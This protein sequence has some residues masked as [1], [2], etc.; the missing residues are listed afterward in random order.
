MKYL[1]LTLSLFYYFSSSCYSQHIDSLHHDCTFHND[2]VI[3]A[4]E[5]HADSLLHFASRYIGTPY[6]MAGHSPKGFDCSGFTMYCFK[7]FG[8]NLPHSAHEQVLLGKD[9]HLAD[10]QPG[11]LLFF[12][13]HD[14]QDHNIHH[15]AILVEKADTH[16]RFIHSASHSVH[17]DNLNSPYYGP[18]FVKIKRL[19]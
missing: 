2:T 4:K 14:M 3:I 9:V 8:Y 1:I 11:D 13:G 10:A 19:Y 12:R 18:R 6:V 5:F 7:H 16:L 17:Y 15:V